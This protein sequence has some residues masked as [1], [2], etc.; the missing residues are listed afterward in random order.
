MTELPTPTPFPEELVADEVL[1]RAIR[2]SSEF[3]DKRFA[4]LLRQNE[5]DSGL[6]VSFN[7]AAEKCEEGL[8]KSYGI[9][10]LI[11]YDVVGL[12]LKVVPDEPTHANIKGIP[13]KD[14][15][16]DLAMWFAGKLRD[17]ARVVREGLKKN[18]SR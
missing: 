17:L 5:R 16:P 15:D 6:S 11:A 14:D 8:N 18:V 7:C 10:S 12:D 4:F 2:T 3:Q 13:Y 1:Y 9:L